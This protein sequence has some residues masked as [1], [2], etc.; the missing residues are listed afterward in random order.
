MVDDSDS[1]FMMLIDVQVNHGGEWWFGCW[2]LVWSL[3]MIETQH[4]GIKHVWNKHPNLSMSW[5]SKRP[6][7][8]WPERNR[9]TRLCDTESDK[10]SRRRSRSM[11]FEYPNLTVFS[12]ANQPFLE[13][14][15]EK[16]FFCFDH[17]FSGRCWWICGQWSLVLHKT[18]VEHM[19]GYWSTY[20]T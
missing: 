13:G 15:I 18:E 3:K 17:F 6:R 9:Y 12:I 4:P 7:W 8:K 14:T 1:W 19:A 2:C 11:L 20:G 10:A 5:E 16:H